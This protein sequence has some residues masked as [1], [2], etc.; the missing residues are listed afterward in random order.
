MNLLVGEAHID[1]EAT[2]ANQLVAARPEPLGVCRARG[3]V[4]L[5]AQV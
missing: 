3:S 5:A 1:G 4:V 2:A